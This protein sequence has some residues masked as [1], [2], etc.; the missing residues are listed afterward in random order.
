VLAGVMLLSIIATSGVF[1]GGAAGVIDQ[2]SG[3]AGEPYLIDDWN[4]LDSIREDPS[5]NYQLSTSLDSETAGYSDIVG[6][7][8]FEP[9]VEFSGEL[10]GQDNTIQAL[11]LNINERD[12][13]YGIFESTT[14]NAKINNVT[15]TGVT[16]IGMSQTQVLLVRWPA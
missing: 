2:G 16:T 1:V 6:D 5:S 3:T 7:N 9:I 10:D 14:S 13:R 12:K 11:K 4:D 8:G 15:L